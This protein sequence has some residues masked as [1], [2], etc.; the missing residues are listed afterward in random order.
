MIIAELSANHGQQKKLAHQ[1][2]A[3]AANAGADAVKV[4]TYTPDTITFNSKQD[5]FIIHGQALWKGQ[6]LW[7]L[8]QSAFT[9]WEWQPE[10]KQQ[11]DELGLKFIASVFDYF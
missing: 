9:P 5:P 8:Y 4:Q 2:I 11:A 3:A 6:S 7:D 1:L 10:L